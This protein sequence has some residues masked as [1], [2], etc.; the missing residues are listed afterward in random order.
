MVTHSNAGRRSRFLALVIMG[1]LAVGCAAA[2]SLGQTALKS[3]TATAAPDWARLVAP[4]AYDMHKKPVVT[5]EERANARA[6]LLH[7][8]F[9]GPD[10]DKVTGLYARPKAAGVYPCVLMLHGWT[11]K[12]DDMA[13]WIGPSIVDQGMSFLA[14]DAPKHGERRAADGKLDFTTMW[15]GITIQGVRDYRLAI[16]WLVSRKDVD[17]RHIGLLG[18]SMGAMMGAI[19]TGVDSRVQAAVLC[20]GGDLFRN[21]AVSIP[22]SMRADSAVISP[23]LFI[24]HISPRPV[25]LLNAKRDFLVSGAASTALFAAAREPKEQRM[26]ESGHILPTD[27][28]V[29]GVAWLAKRLKPGANR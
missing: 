24:G 22:E 1:A 26:F 9:T 17:A 15:R 16:P 3:A 27:A 6:Y 19:F 8:E 28:L 5:V 18:Y 12:K 7:I 13:L 25:L 14:L 21:A 23:S 29:G 4:Y 2:P 10:G 11:S 20:V